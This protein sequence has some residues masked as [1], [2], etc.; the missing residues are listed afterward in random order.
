MVK[1]ESYYY[2]KKAYLL[3]LVEPREREDEV[4]L[5][6]LWESTDLT[7]SLEWV[8]LYAWRSMSSPF[9]LDSHRALS[10]E[11]P[12]LPRRMSSYRSRS[13]NFNFQYRCYKYLFLL[14]SIKLRLIISRRKL[15]FVTLLA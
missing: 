11:E 1:I 13:I 15:T 7:E 14:K 4:D 3:S 12:D 2:R 10:E 5:C 8:S 6:D 9:S